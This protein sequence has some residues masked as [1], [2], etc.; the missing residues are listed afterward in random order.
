MKFM[1]ISKCGE[2]AGLLHR[3]A[4]EG[5]EVKLFINDK[6]YKRSWKGLLPQATPDS[7]WVDDKT[8]F[9]FDYSEMGEFADNLKRRGHKVFGA[10]SFADKLEHDRAFGMDAM[11]KAGIKIPPTFDFSNND[12]NEARKFIASNDSKR[13]VFK[14]SGDEIPSKL[15]YCGCDCEDL[16]HY[17]TFVEKYYKGTIKEFILQEFVE[18]TIVSTEMFCD[19]TKL[20]GPANHTVEVK[21]FMNEDIGPSTGCAGNVVWGE[22][23]DCWI[24]EKGIKLIEDLCVEHSYIGPIDLNA[25]INDSGLYGLEWTPRFGYDAMPTLLQL[26]SIDVSQVISDLCSGDLKSFPIDE[27]LAAGIRVTI[28]PY[29]LEPNKGNIQT[30]SPNLGI[31]I[32]GIKD[33]SLENIY[34]FEIMQDEEEEI[35][36]SDGTGVVF[37]ASDVGNSVDNA[38]KKPYKIAEDCKIPDKQ[39][40]T[41][42]DIVLS[43]MFYDVEQ[44]CEA[45]HGR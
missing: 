8:I 30:I 35:V 5:N 22:F 34:F 13:Y 40:R 31:P 27:G 19:G 38:L 28:P 14:P 15:T 37:V 44:L 29:P 11:K 9:I 21:K 1:M 45:N 2:G 16:L 42:L 3:I 43:N 4:S 33:D 23:N 36:H 10:S 41:D 18:G 24:V 12:W 32:R 7:A 39:Y 17:L 26:I 25:I 6:D 20:V